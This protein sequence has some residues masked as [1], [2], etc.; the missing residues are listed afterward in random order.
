MDRF[1]PALH[2]R[3]VPG[4]Y[5]RGIRRSPAVIST[6]AVPE[7]LNDDMGTQW[8]ARLRTLARRSARLLTG[9]PAGGSSVVRLDD[10]NERRPITVIAMLHVPVFVGR[11]LVGGP[12]PV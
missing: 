1:R 5:S 4:A 2:R 9:S 7:S 12:G 11:M 10:D 8:R 3:I 6:A